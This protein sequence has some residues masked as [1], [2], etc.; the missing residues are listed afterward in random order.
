MMHRAVN[1]HIGSESNE[2]RNQATEAL[3]RALTALGCADCGAFG[4]PSSGLEPETPPYHARES[5]I[6]E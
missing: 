5:R 2:R 4:K 3:E 6:V 1:A